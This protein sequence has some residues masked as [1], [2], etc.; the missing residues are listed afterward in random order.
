MST[1]E[2]AYGMRLRPRWMFGPI[3]GLIAF[4]MITFG[5]IQV[6]HWAEHRDCAAAYDKQWGP[7]VATV[8]PN[9]GLSP[10]PTLAEFCAHPGALWQ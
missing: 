8:P 5:G 9:T 1:V 7:L 3:G 10:M 2:L 4:V 6:V